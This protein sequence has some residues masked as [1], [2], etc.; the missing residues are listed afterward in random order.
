M[1]A[2]TQSGDCRRV[3]VAYDHQVFSWQEYGGISRYFYE[4]AAR[5]DTASGFS[6]SIIAP[7]HINRYLGGRAAA[8]RGVKVPVLP[9]TLRLR[10]AINRY[11][12]AALVRLAKPDLLHET[13][14]EHNNYAYKGCPVVI[15]IHDMIH[16]KFADQF[17]SHDRASEAK[18]DAVRRADRVICV[19]ENT[20]R[21][22]IELFDADP[23]K[24]DTIHLG[25][26]LRRNAGELLAPISRRPYLLYV[27]QRGGHKNFL[28]LVDA[29]VSDARIRS[30]FD[31]VAFGGT[32]FTAA[33]V[34]E[35]RR[36]AGPDAE[37]IRHL[38]GDDTRLSHAYIN[39]TALVYPSLYE[40]FGIPPLEA[41]SMGCPVLCSDTSSI[42]EVVGDAGLY[43][44]PRSPESIRQA[45][46]TVVDSD[47]LCSTMAERGRSRV[48]LFS[49]ER[50][51]GQTMDVYRTL[52]S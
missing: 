51:A 17:A 4:L 34:A 39:A 9:N 41:M 47:E 22:L 29:Y 10:G 36:K 16:E 3:N 7:L 20:R 24:I 25:F 44:D 48:K 14:Y 13:Y 38:S 6:A 19:S 28:T 12:S 26:A 23:S 40:G 52:M 35:I 33:E 21:D 15:T 11:A 37:R 32:P 49:Y 27:G 18:R 5:V 30:N 8:V 43:F 50:C 2:S 45:I 1:T 46:C 42:P 31:L